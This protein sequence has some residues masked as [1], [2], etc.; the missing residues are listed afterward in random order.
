MT[1]SDLANAIVVYTTIRDAIV[2]LESDGI[3]NE[4]KRATLVR[5]ALRLVAN[6][7]HMTAYMFV[8]RLD[9][10]NIASR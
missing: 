6:T 9:K 1:G 5:G 8:N 10:H 4:T 2:K 7:F 3:I